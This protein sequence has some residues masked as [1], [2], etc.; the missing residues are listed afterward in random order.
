MNNKIPLLLDKLI[1]LTKENKLNWKTYDTSNSIF[2]FEKTALFDADASH[3]LLSKV[4]SPIYSRSYVA[5]YNNGYIGLIAY[6]NMAI[7]NYVVLVLQADNHS[8]PHT[9]VTSNNKNADVSAKLKRL[10]NLIDLDVEDANLL[11]YI[12][13]I[14]ND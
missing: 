8:L 2:D 6:A 3:V 11:E 12:E 1:T 10:Y 7:S 5:Q 9:L 14:L 4:V 13:E